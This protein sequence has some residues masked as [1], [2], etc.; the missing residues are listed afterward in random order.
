MLTIAIGFDFLEELWNKK[1]HELFYAYFIFIRCSS[2]KNKTGNYILNHD[3]Q[4][5]EYTN[6]K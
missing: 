2:F 3:K 4:K 5:F 1:F 6:L